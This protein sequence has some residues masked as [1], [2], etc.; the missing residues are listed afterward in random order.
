MHLHVLIGIAGGSGPAAKPRKRRVIVKKAFYSDE[1]DESGDE[2]AQ[3]AVKAEKGN[4]R[5]KSGCKFPFVN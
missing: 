3:E 1:E 4:L 2:E 5:L